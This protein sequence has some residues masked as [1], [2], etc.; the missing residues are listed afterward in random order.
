MKSHAIN[1]A[2][3]VNTAA[4]ICA[5]TAR[6]FWMLDCRGGGVKSHGLKMKGLALQAIQ[7][8]PCVFPHDFRSE[9]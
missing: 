4:A 2:R 1:G 5:F 9:D 3:S 6:I 7:T 8:D